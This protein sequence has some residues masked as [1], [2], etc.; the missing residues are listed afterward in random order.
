[1]ASRCSNRDGLI[2]AGGRTVFNASSGLATMNGPYSLPRKP[3]VWNAFN[4]SPSP[5]SKRWPMLM[6]AGTAGLFQASPRAIN[7]AKIWAAAVWGRALTEWHWDLLTQGTTED[8][9]AGREETN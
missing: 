7:V 1:M 3:A 8:R 5:K 2:P 6:K 4:S 9:V